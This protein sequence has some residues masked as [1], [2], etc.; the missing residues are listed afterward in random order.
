MIDELPAG[1]LLQLGTYFVTLYSVS[2]PET[3]TVRYD[4]EL[5][6][7][8]LGLPGLGGVTAYAMQPDPGVACDDANHADSRYCSLWKNF[9]ELACT[10]G[11]RRRCGTCGVQRCAADGT[12][13][14][15]A[16][17]AAC[18]PAAGGM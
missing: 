11:Q 4:D 14:G 1:R 12:W 16:G 5:V 6:R 10:P 9:G 18:G 3:P 13:Q 15:C 7:L 8:A 17:D 2:P